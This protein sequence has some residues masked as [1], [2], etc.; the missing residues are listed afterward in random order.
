MGS[1]IP[2]SE[3]RGRRCERH[4]LGAGPDGLCALCRSE[5]LPP[6]QARW[7]TRVSVLALGGVLLVCGGLLAHRA[8]RAMRS[9]VAPESVVREAAASVLSTTQAAKTAG[10]AP[11][12][13]QTAQS[14][15]LEQPLPPPAAPA[16][17][18]VAPPAASSPA[19]AALSASKPPPSQAELQ[20]ALKATPIVMYATTWCGVCR[21]ARQFMAENGLSYQEID[22]DAT[23]GGWD[24]IQQL[25]GEKAVPVIVVDGVVSQ[26]LRPREVMHAVAKSMERRLGITGVTFRTSPKPG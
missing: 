1:D 5:S 25:S 10:E 16:L 18:A 21:K 2:V 6:P 20:A 3:R 22:A 7:S 12:A 24:K 13:P 11:A 8:T 23:P 4:G 17:D 15:P 26:G 9:V 19:R 14:F